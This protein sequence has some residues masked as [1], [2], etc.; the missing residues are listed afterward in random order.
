MPLNEVALAAI[1]PAAG[2]GE[3]LFTDPRGRPF[4]DQALGLFVRQLRRSRPDWTD[5]ATDRPF[6]ARGLRATFRSWSAATRQDRE[7]TELAMGHA[8]VYGAVEGAYVRDPLDAHR[9][10]LMARWAKHCRGE[11]A[12]IVPLRA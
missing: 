1:P 9:A 4:T 12:V 5:P 7:L 2:A 6:T 8:T 10:E 11:T 3:Y